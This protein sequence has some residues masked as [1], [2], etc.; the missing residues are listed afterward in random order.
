MRYTVVWL[1]SAVD[2]LAK[3]WTR[4]TDRKA[5]QQAADQIDLQ[6]KTSSLA[7]FADSQGTY[8]LTAAPLRFVIRISPDDLK[9]TVLQ[10]DRLP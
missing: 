9:V 10:V 7:R 5:V 2:E 8:E 1:P 6:L 3:I 4:A